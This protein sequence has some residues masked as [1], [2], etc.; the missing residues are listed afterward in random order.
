MDSKKLT[1]KQRIGVVLATVFGV[2]AVAFC[3]AVFAII[4]LHAD[5]NG[6]LPPALSLQ[7]LGLYE[8]DLKVVP[9]PAQPGAG[10]EDKLINI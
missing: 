6:M 2:F 9:K 7:P 4:F 8:P 3:A 1:I 10:Q 5:K